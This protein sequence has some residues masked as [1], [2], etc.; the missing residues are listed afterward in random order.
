MTSNKTYYRKCKYC[1]FYRTDNKGHMKCVIDEVPVQVQARNPA[2]HR[3]LL[4]E[5]GKYREY[6]KE[7]KK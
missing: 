1:Y 3:F 5:D 7:E 6:L 2:C 4:W